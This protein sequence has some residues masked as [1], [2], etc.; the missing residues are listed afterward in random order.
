MKI[1]LIGRALFVALDFVHGWV[2]GVIVIKNIYRKTKLFNE[3]EMVLKVIK[4]FSIV[5]ISNAAVV[6]I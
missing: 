6:F 2:F 3:A 1:F 4:N 5:L